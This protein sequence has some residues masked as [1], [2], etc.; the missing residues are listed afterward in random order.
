MNREKKE[1]EKLIKDLMYIIAKEP[2]EDKTLYGFF[3]EYETFKE[4]IKEQ[5]IGILIS[6]IQFTE[7]EKKEL[8]E[9]KRKD[10]QKLNVS[11][12]D[13]NKYIELEKEIYKLFKITRKYKEEYIRELKKLP[14]TI[15]MRQNNYKKYFKNK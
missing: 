5:P 14:F 2:V 4:R 9:K 1:Y 10:C 8:E 3:S 15:N 6:E 12:D 7:S 11:L 13:C